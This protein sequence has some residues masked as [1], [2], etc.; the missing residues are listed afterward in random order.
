MARRR[1][2]EEGWRVATHL[3]IVAQ[4]V[5]DPVGVAADET[6]AD[7]LEREHKSAAWPL[8]HTPGAL[9]LSDAQV[10]GEA[11]PGRRLG[12]QGGPDYLDVGRQRR[13]GDDR[14]RAPLPTS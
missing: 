12:E 10:S 3:V 5:M 14:Q 4:R 13:L 9:P 2:V 8:H 6:P 11:G 7:P 1:L